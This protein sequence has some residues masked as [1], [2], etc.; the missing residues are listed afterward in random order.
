MAFF[1]LILICLCK[2][3]RIT[4]EYQFSSAESTSSEE[5]KEALMHMLQAHFPGSGG[6]N[7]DN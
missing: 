2:E 6:L 5:E 7:E 3:P 1:A 4:F